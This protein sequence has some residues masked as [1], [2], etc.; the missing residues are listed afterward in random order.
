MSRVTH[1]RHITASLLPLTR[2]KTIHFSPLFALSTVV[3]FDKV[4]TKPNIFI[5]L[6]AQFQDVTTGK[7]AFEKIFTGLKGVDWDNGGIWRTTAPQVQFYNGKAYDCYYYLNDAW[8]KDAEGKDAYKTGWSDGFGNYV[9]LTAA[10]GQGFWFI[11]P[12]ADAAE[13]CG[14]GQVE[15]SVEATVE[16]PGGVF[17]ILANVF[18]MAV[19]LNDEKHVTADGIVGVDWDSDDAW[20]STAPQIQFF[21][22]TDYDIYYYLNDGYVMEGLKI[23]GRK[24]GWCDMDGRYVDVAIPAQQSFWVK[25]N[26]G[27]FKFTFKR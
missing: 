11:N 1:L 23:V 18:P 14:A 26:T 7:L 6:A 8:Y 17:A 21:N 19:N 24:K 3:G 15:E 27:K 5:Q 12:S 22:G 20:L 16:V 4:A 25:A 13:I 9:D 2:S 10:P